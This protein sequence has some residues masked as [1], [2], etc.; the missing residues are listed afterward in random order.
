MEEYKQRIRD[1]EEKASRNHYVLHALQCFKTYVVQA[2]ARGDYKP[3]LDELMAKSRAEA[4]QAKNDENPDEN[5][6]TPEKEADLRL[7]L[8]YVTH[9]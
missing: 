3:K 1:A 7:D 5:P 9:S 2:A 4:D 8:A 6:P